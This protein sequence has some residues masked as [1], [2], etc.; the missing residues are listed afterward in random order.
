MYPVRTMCH[1]LG[2]SPSG[3]YA[4]LK[5]EPSERSV[6]N[7]ELLERIREIHEWSDGTY[8]SPRIHEELR[9]TQGI[10]VGMKRGGALDGRG[11][12]RGRKPSERD[13]GDP[14]R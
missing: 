4:W 2:V 5:R 7:A 12:A 9:K 13:N 14:A 3:Y 8:G 1:V 10:G 11:W 6:A